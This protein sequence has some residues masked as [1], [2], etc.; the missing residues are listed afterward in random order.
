MIERERVTIFGGI[1][2]HYHDLAEEP[3]LACRDT[4]S[5]KSAWIGGSPVMIHLYVDDVDA[6]ANQAVAAGATL[7]QPVADQFYGDRMGVLQDPFGHTWSFAT[8]IEDLSPEEL[9]KRAAQHGGCPEQ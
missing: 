4:T 9:Q 8:H 5:L 2:T 3:T 6:L 7:L 1:P